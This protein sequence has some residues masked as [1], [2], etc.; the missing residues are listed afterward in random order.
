VSQETWSGQT[1]GGKSRQEDG[2]TRVI[3]SLMALVVLLLGARVAGAQTP[4]PAAAAEPERLDPVVV[5]A[6]KAPTPVG[7]TGSSVTVIEQREIQS[8]QVT[9]MLEILRDVPGLTVNQTGSRGGATSIFT[10]GGNADMNQVLID[11]MKVNL[12][13]GAFDFANLTTVGI[14]RAEIVRGPQSALYGP[15]AMTSVMQFFTPRGEGPL[16][17]WGSVKGGNYSTDEERTGAS[18]GN[19]QG[20]AFFEFGRVHTGGVLDINNSYTSYTAALRLDL[21]PIPDLTLTLTGRYIS[22]VFHFPT[23]NGDLVDPVLDPHQFQETEQFVGSLGVRYRQA[24]WIEHRFKV[25]GNT[26]SSQFHDPTDVPPDFPGPNTLNKS[27]ENRLLFDYNMMLSAPK[28]AEIVSTVVVGASYEE[29][30]FH[31]DNSPAFGPNPI[32]ESRHTWSGYGELHAAWRDRI[33]LTLGGR[34]DDSTA[35]GQAFSPRVTAA[36][37]APVTETRL[38]G[39]YGQ[40]IKAPS[41]FD[42][43]GG[44]GIPGNPDLKPEKSESWEVG[45]D[46]PLFGNLFQAGVTYFHN[47]F[48]DLI[49]FVS[50]NEGSKN[51]QAARTQGVETVFTLRPIRGWRANASYTYLDTTVTDDGGIGGQNT[52]PQG[53]PLLRRPRHS[54]SVSIGYQQ[55]RLSAEATLYVKGA[56]IDLDFGQPGGPRVNLP[57]YQKLDLAVA[58]TLF[59]DVVGLRDVVW[60]TVFQ[61][62]LNQNY[63]EVKNFSSPR[64]SALTGIEVRY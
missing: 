35:F 11:G 40:G 2:M 29:E 37:V 52:F 6:T 63:Q 30:R 32:D 17:V 14:G 13:G 47:D 62:V 1:A 26:L 22:S 43:F 28:V 51:I 34:Y 33:F 41:F 19:Q 5:S 15:D 20:G 24:S 44:F 49:A 25:G 58:Y 21:E 46:Q 61:N 4:A 57:G 36:V 10:R 59:R 18:W 53:Q 8:R 50:F 7:E 16:S 12:G 48:K 42:Q 39:A 54:G 27:N 3:S 56:S 9:D 23:E 31:Q 55:N 38:R 60:K 64:F 45:F